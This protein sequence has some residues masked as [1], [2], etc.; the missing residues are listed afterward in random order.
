M[1]VIV[2]MM[3]MIQAVVTDV[4]VVQVMM[5]VMQVMMSEVVR[6]VVR[7]SVGYVVRVMMMRVGDMVLGFRDDVSDVRGRVVHMLRRVN[8]D[9]RTVGRDAHLEPLDQ[10]DSPQSGSSAQSDESGDRP[11]TQ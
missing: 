6:L 3:M 5:P 7:L 1:L 9:G 8:V 10:V 4:Q 11:A 2:M